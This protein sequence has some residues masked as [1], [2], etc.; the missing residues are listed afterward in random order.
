M[1]LHNMTLYLRAFFF[2]TLS[3]SKHTDLSE[4]SAQFAKITVLKSPDFLDYICLSLLKHFSMRSKQRA[5]WIT[6]QSR[7]LIP[8]FNTIF[9]SD[10]FPIDLI[11]LKSNFALHH[12]WLENFFYTKFLIA[13]SHRVACRF[14]LNFLEFPDTSPRC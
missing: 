6:C 5:T 2:P 1:S 12:S 11:I 4:F 7:A 8:H 14:A 3:K 13:C 10:I 9:V